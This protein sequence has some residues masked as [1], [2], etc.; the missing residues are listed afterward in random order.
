MDYFVTSNNRVFIRV[1]K[2]SAFEFRDVDIEEEVPNKN[3]PKIMDK[4]RTKTIG[5]IIY[6]ESSTIKLAHQYAYEFK[7]FVDFMQDKGEMNF[8]K[9]I[10]E[11]EKN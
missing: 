8:L 7:A 11:E 9:S 1:D 10:S 4:I 3:N 6:F 2:I 5:C